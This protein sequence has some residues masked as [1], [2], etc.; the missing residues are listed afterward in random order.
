M[1]QFN[2]N[3]SPF[4]PDILPL[5]FPNKNKS[6]YIPHQPKPKPEAKPLSTKQTPLSPSKFISS[7]K[8]WAIVRS[9]R[10]IFDCK[11][12]LGETLGEDHASAC[13]NIEIPEV[14]INT[15]EFQIHNAPPIL[16][17]YS[18]SLGDNTFTAT[19]REYNNGSGLG[20]YGWFK[21]WVER[22]VYTDID[23]REYSVNYYD[24]ILGSAIVKIYDIDGSL[25][26]EIGL[27]KIY[28]TSIKLS[29]F[30]HAETNNYVKTTVKF[31]FEEIDYKL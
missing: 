7:L 30:D 27:K 10:F 6:A 18:R 22:V 25:L 8:K 16:I 11:N 9:N 14:A 17:P 13:E 29:T 4:P 21:S 23:T 19:F 26:K 28:P 2:P 3:G 31:Y 20:L 15:S 12:D 24:D 1:T 5:P